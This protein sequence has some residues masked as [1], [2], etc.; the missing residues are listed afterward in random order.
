MIG[1]QQ[2]CSLKS[3]DQADRYKM[4]AQAIGSTHAPNS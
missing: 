4:D 1:V 3:S 2:H